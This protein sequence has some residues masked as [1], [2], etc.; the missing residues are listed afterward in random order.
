[1]PTYKGLTVD[2][3]RLALVNASDY[4]Y[5]RNVSILSDQEFDDMKDWL[6]DNFPDDPFLYTIGAPLPKNLQWKKATHKIAMSSLNKCNIIEEFDAWCYKTKSTKF[7]LS[8]K[9]DGISIDIEYD[10]GHLKKAI[11]RGEDGKV[12]EDITVNVVR[13]QG[14]YISLPDKFTGS[15]RGEIILKEADFE[16]IN[17]VRKLRGDKPYKA[18]R[19]AASGI[20]RGYD[21]EYVEF[22]TVKFYDCTKEFKTVADRF[23]FLQEDL[24]LETALIVA[25]VSAKTVVAEHK[26]YEDNIRADLDYEIDGLVIEVDDMALKEELGEKNHNPMGAIA[27]KFGSIRRETTV[28]DVLWQMGK[29][30]RIT[31]VAVLAPVKMGGVIVQRASLHN[32][33]MYND[34]APRQG[35]TVIVSRRNDVIPYVESIVKRSSKSVIPVIKE[36]PVCNEPTFVNGKFL[37]C[38]NPDCD[39]KTVGHLKKWIKTLDL[40]GIGEGIIDALYSFEIITEPADFYRLD[41]EE[42]QVLPGFGKSSARKIVD[43]INGSKQI[44]LRLFLGGLNIPNWGRRMFDLLIEDGY[45][46]LDKVLNITESEL[47]TIKGIE[48]KTARALK[49]GLDKKYPIIK[50]LLDYVTIEKPKPK[51]ELKMANTDSPIAGKS[52]VFT[53]KILREDDDGKR[54]KRSMLQDIVIENGG[55]TPSSISG[56]VDY[57]VQADPDSQ[58]T[59][60]KKAISAGIEILSEADFFKM[61]GM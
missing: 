40:K 12:G 7:V 57:L 17:E 19:N 14:V 29:S 25:G 47:V 31:P 10:K 56:N 41:V 2:E 13:M 50:D 60:T 3:V 53:G 30:G 49:D 33:E 24:G 8:E 35:D 28:L 11:T 1:M 55:K 5:N 27:F 43:T 34:L 20:A 6:Q 54:F 9:L 38:S 23:V 46:T 36:C 59:K 52:F 61:A 26:N 42:I 44:H 45:D 48:E 4:Y 22:C 37:E 58:S 21:G 32:I 15:I 18:L 51:K 39:G 16:M